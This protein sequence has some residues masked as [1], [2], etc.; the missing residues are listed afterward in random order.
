MAF[1]YDPDEL[2]TEPNHIRFLIQDTVDTGH[3][4]EDAEL[5]FALSQDTNVYRVAAGLCR[6][7]ATKLAK[8]PSLDDATVKFEA[9]KRAE[10]YLKLATAYD[11]KAEEFEDSLDSGT[12]NS[13]MSF[14]SLPDRDPSFT[15]DLHFS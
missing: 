5:I 12:G 7:A 6:A 9:D 2:S 14:P 8:T 11:K 3:F 13:G 10:T 1:S 15:R 4:F